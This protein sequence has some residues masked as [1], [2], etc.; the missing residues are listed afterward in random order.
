MNPSSA[1]ALVSA[2]VMSAARTVVSAS[3]LMRAAANAI[4]NV[5]LR[6]L[7]CFMF[8]LVVYDQ[9]AGESW[10][11]L[12]DF[13]PTLVDCLY[14]EVAARSRRTWRARFAIEAPLVLLFS[15]C[16]LQN[17]CMAISVLD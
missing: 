8:F 7:V 9:N 11:C 17:C 1:M 4:I 15:L 2:G 3:A 6:S 14:C 5:P 12:W 10:R 16:F 13:R